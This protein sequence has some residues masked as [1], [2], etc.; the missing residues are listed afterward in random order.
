MTPTE[1]TAI[2]D[3]ARSLFDLTDAELEKILADPEQL[4]AIADVLA[5]SES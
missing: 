5:T 2:L 1:T 3:I 4:L